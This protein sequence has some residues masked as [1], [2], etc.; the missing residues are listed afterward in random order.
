MSIGIYIINTKFIFL[1]C[2]STKTGL[3][4]SNTSSLVLKF[5]CPMA[6]QQHMHQVPAATDDAAGKRHCCLLLLSCLL[7]CCI[8]K[9]SYYNKANYFTET[10]YF[11]QMCQT[12]LTIFYAAVFETR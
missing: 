1:N 3:P 7:C 4:N 2:V 11:V 9:V 6:M 5:V 8:I 12:L 10:I